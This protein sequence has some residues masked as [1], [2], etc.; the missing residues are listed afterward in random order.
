M[1]KKK[2]DTPRQDHSHKIKS[3]AFSKFIQ[4]FTAFPNPPEQLVKQLEKLFYKFL[5]NICCNVIIQDVKEG[6]LRMIKINKFIESLKVTW[7]R[8]I[9]I[10][11][12]GKFVEQTFPC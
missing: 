4:L 2:A 12:N 9:L 8:R 1:V 6:G 11:S 3:L 7:L 10:S 5:T